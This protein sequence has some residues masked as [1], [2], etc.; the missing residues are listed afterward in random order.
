MHVDGHIETFRTRDN[1][2]ERHSG[3]HE[4]VPAVATPRA[5]RPVSS[6][7]DGDGDSVTGDDQHG[8]DI[9]GDC[10]PSYEEALHM[11]TPRDPHSP[12]YANLDSKTADNHMT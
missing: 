2:Q 8:E 6:A 7:E 9:L 4:L 12:L 10:P 3:D 1:A 5:T 11:P